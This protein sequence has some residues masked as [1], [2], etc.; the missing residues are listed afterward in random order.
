MGDGY[1]YGNDNIDYYQVYYSKW[2][3]SQEHNVS[4]SGGTG[5]THTIFRLI[6]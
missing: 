2:A 4:F 3:P 6:T 5:K 1:D